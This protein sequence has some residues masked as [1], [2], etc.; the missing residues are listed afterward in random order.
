VNKVI[1]A[2]TLVASGLPADDIA[3]AIANFPYDGT[4][5]EFVNEL[6]DA[7]ATSETA[8]AVARSANIPVSKKPALVPTQ[9]PSPAPTAAATAI[10]TGATRST[11]M[12]Q[13]VEPKVAPKSSHVVS[14]SSGSIP[15]VLD[16]D[17]STDDILSMLSALSDPSNRRKDLPIV[18]DRKQFSGV[19]TI[20]P[21]VP[22]PQLQQQ[23]LHQGQGYTVTKVG[24][25]P[26]GKSVWGNPNLG[27]T[28][29]PSGIGRS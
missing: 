23:P 1:I 18:R 26:A 19:S 20:Q 15:G 3:H 8:Q 14:R 10:A 22:P 24:A 21:P 11:T 27:T 28:S 12:R 13:P 9:I 6:V 29:V 7:G 16:T 25:A 5:T 4:F 17:S 2:K